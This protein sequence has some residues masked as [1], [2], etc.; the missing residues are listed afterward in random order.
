MPEYMYGVREDGKVVSIEDIDIGSFGLRCRCKC[1]KCHRDLQA[2]SLKSEKVH[3]YFRHNNEGYNPEGIDSLNG[4]NATSANE[5]GLH[6]MAKEIIAQTRKIAFPPMILALEQLGLSFDEEILSRLPQSIPL[7]SGVVFSCDE[8]VEVEK[9]YPQF[10]PDVSVCGG[11]QRFLIEIAVTHRVDAD[12][13]E[14]VRSYGLPMLEI[15]LRR[16][17]ETGISR[18]ALCRVIAEEMDHK[19]WIAFPKS[20]LER[21]ITELTQKAEQLEKQR[22]AQE[23]YRK[24]SFSPDVYGRTLAGNR[25]DAAFDRY[26]RRGFHFEATHGEYPFFIDIPISGEIVFCCDR[27]IWQGKLFDR[28]VYYRNSDRINLFSVWEGLIREGNIPYDPVLAGKFPYPGNEE[29]RYL[30]YEVIREYFGYLEALGFVAIEGKWATVRKK[31]SLD[32]PNQEYAAFLKSVLGQADESSPTV[33]RSLRRKL[34]GLVRAEQERREEQALALLRI[35]AERRKLQEETEKREAEIE[36]RKQAEAM[37][38]AIRN[39]DY[40]QSETQIVIGGQRWLLCTCCGKP[41][42]RADMVLEGFPTL[43]KGMCRACGRG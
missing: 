9:P 24:E 3:R 17:V 15:D 22:A 8:V 43:N 37:R 33:S 41:H 11:G 21:T 36:K 12:K 39:A 4:C 5:S 16:F 6:L 14:K 29:P 31:H 40:D 1:P 20:D 32:P 25:N 34:D 23:K 19:A 10:R 38:L 42:R 27:R 26:A 30:P 7:R 13:R 35:E 28:W 18:E 2:C